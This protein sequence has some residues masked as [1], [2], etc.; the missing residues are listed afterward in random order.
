MIEL[1][2]SDRVR[3]FDEVLYYHNWPTPRSMTRDAKSM[4]E[5]DTFLATRQGQ[6]PYCRLG[7]RD[8]SPRR[9]ANFS[10]KMFV[11]RLSSSVTMAVN[12]YEE[13]KEKWGL[14]E[15]TDGT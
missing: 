10:D 8:S 2:G 7:S 4:A 9:R 15:K 1:S 3:F 13:K 12:P 5:R 11:K 6:T 14:K